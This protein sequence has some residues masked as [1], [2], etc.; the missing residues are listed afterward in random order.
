MTCM[1]HL[2]QNDR[3]P[4]DHIALLTKIKSQI[5]CFNSPSDMQRYEEL[6]HLKE[7]LN[8]II[9]T[10]EYEAKVAAAKGNIAELRNQYVKDMLEK[11]DNAEKSRAEQEKWGWSPLFSIFKK[12]PLPN[13]RNS[14][15]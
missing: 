7:Y 8:Y 10:R 9:Q 14:P 3:D 4:E 5:R 1:F 2:F 11:F 6:M 13:F 15:W 12:W